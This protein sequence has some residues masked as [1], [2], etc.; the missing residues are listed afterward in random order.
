M[1][2]QLH[3]VVYTPESMLQHPGRLI[4]QMLQDVRSSRSL[5]WRLFVRDISALYRQSILGYAW[6][7]LPPLVAALPWVFLSAQKIL[8]LQATS[9]PYPVYVMVGMMLWQT[10]I[11]ALHSPLK[12]ATAARG[13]LTKINFPREALIM[14]GLAEVLFNFA[15]RILLLVPVYLWFQIPLGVALCLAPVGVL[16]LI[17]LGLAL[18]LLITP[19]ALLY[20]DLSRGITLATGFWMLLTPVVYPP[21]ATNPGALLARWN[22]VSPVLLT[23]RDWF[24]GAPAAH[25]SGFLLVTCASVVLLL[26]AWL[27]YRLTMPI[28]V[29][30]MGA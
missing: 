24:T 4:S 15:V 25:L 23:A 28:L 8:Q 29:E 16:A 2:S 10:F 27:L 7:L 6:A 5:A 9:V 13:M 21:P 3:E 1:K 17:V 22:P 18:G 30:R 14:A 26:A 12:Q 19:A 11:D 20:T